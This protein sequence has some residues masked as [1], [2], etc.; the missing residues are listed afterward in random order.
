M[1]PVEAYARTRSASLHGMSRDGEALIKAARLL[2]TA[3]MHPEDTKSL[4]EA[5][6]FNTT[7]WTVFQAD[8]SGEENTLSDEL[9]A[10]LLSLS[11]FMDNSAA[12][13]LEHYD[14]DTLDAMIEAN[15]NIAS[16]LLTA[17]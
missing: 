8:L 7:L 15:R 3:R 2:N 11:L 5:L 9:K 14:A 16:A 1:S 6:D 12:K 10:D 13:L 4:A 17:N